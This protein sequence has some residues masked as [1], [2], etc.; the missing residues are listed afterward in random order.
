MDVDSYFKE[1][2]LTVSQITGYVKELIE[3]VPVFSGMKIR[4]EI[5]NFVAHRSGHLYFSLKD[6]G[7]VLKAVMFARD[8]R[9]LDAPVQDGMKVVAVGRLTVYPPSG[10]YQMVVSSMTPDG[11]GA[12]YEAYEKLRAKLSEEGLFSEAYKRP[13]PKYPKTIGVITSPTGAAVRD[14]INVT[15]RR[16]PYAKIV[17]YPALVQGEGAAQSLISGIKYFKENPADTVIIGR[18]GGSIEDLWAFN[19]EQLAREIAGSGLAVISAVGHE[20]D[21]TI[22]DFAA[23]VRA[24]TPS[25][26][27]ELA[28]PD[29]NTV[30]K[31]FD[32]MEKR[33]VFQIKNKLSA[34]NE[35]ISK[36]ES[37]RVLA[38]PY[39]FIDEKR[40]MLSSYY[41]RLE[42]RNALIL[43]EKKAAFA[44]LSGKLD[45]LSPLSVLSRGY[46][47][48]FSESGT[49]TSVRSVKEGDRLKIS[50]H[51]GSIGAVAEYV[52]ENN[53]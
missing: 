3:S 28:A 10:Q 30:R 12:L 11:K 27:A 21:Y 13:I 16:W 38:S 20:T 6:E 45:A 2:T 34:L 8:V 52:K 9:A 48:L 42:K 40:L 43:S 25:A 51:D 41:D 7:A 50:M 47:A 22:C 46:G 39:G 26:A 1:N 14:M 49:V 36:L 33:A 31:A 17:I 19:N 24:P 32:E 5:S 35:L 4:G 29:I 37:K 53:E 18:G 15:K 44:A 23:S